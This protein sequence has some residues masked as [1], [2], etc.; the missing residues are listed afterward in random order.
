MI[1]S[2][3]TA[4]IAPRSTLKTTSP[5][6]IEAMGTLPRGVATGVSGEAQIHIGHPTGH[7]PPTG[8]VHV[9]PRTMGPG[10]SQQSCPSAQHW[11]P[12]QNVEPEQLVP[13]QGG[14]AHEP[15]LQNG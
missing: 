8:S 15:P 12:Q 13:V 9:E 11:S 14:M 1:S 2:T 4:T 10:T 5:T 7:V 3:G 6:S